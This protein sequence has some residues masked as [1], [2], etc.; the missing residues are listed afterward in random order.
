[1]TPRLAL[2][3]SPTIERGGETLALPFERRGQLL[4]F[5]ALRR[6]WVG[7]AELAAMFWPEQPGKLAY[8]N[9][10][11]L[12]FRL[13]S[14]PWDGLIESQGGAV[15]CEAG[16]DVHDFEAALRTGLVAEA[17]ALRRGDLLAGFDDDASEAWSGWLSFERE[18][19]RSAWRGAVL[20]RLDAIDPAEGVELSAQLLE[21]D[22]LDEG[23]LSVHVS[24]LA[25]SGQQAR[26]RQAYREFSE[27]LEKDLG[28]A[29]GPALKALHEGLG[30]TAAAV[31]IE[32]PA[33]DDSFV[34]RSVELGRIGELLEQDDCRLVCL[35]G[36]GGVGKTRLARRALRQHAAGFPAGA[37]FVPLEDLSSPG[38]LGGQLARELGIAHGS[39]VEPLDSVIEFLRAR[40]ALLVLDNFEHLAAAAPR[41]A[42]LLDACPGVKI[43]VTSRV[44]TGLP[45]EWLLPL[46]GLPCPE[47]EDQDRIEAFDAARLFVKAARRFAPSLNPSVEAPSIVDICRQVEGLPLALEMAAAWTRFLTCEA[48]A[49]ELRGGMELLRTVD[50]TRPARHASIEAVFE[51]SWRLLTP[52]ERGGLARLSVFRGGFTPEAARAAGTP[53]PI[54]GALADKSLVRKDEARIF[55]HPLVQQMAAA[56]LG[57]E[58]ARENAHAAHARYFHQLLAQ[59]RGA[60]EGG[61]REA[62]QRLD[63]ELENCRVAWRWAATHA[64]TD[65]LEK[66][67]TTLLH[68][69]DH[70]GRH[71]EGLALMREALESPG[72]AAD[73]KCAA[74][75]ASFAAHLAYRLDRYAV[76]EKDATRALATAHS[77][78]QADAELQSLT[79]LGSL[80]FRLGRHADARRFFA[81]ALKLT[82]A[83]GALRKAAAMMANLALVEKAAGH[84]DESLRHLIES[85]AQYRGIGDAAGEALTL[86]NIGSLQVARGHLE[87]ARLHLTPALA[88]SERHGLSY[89]RALILA[90]LAELELKAGN[91]EA[92]Q[93][94]AVGGIELAEATGNRYLVSFLKLQ[95]ARF[96]LRRGDLRG[97]RSEIASAATLAIAIGQPTLLAECAACFGELLAAQG[98]KDCE[99]LVAAFASLPVN[100]LA[101]RIVVEADVAHAPLIALLRGSR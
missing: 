83:S 89:N 74:L 7:R 58:E 3:G 63:T 31:A 69:C 64:R 94:H 77:T 92:A 16:T 19:L 84:H 4:A 76:A 48:I 36:P 18:R 10:R 21:A 79:V 101:H 39:A 53:L 25:R 27:R 13:Q 57:E 90:N 60:V 49:A 11:K 65:A 85:L 24:C 98:E 66:S 61:D 75:L 87:S 88:L 1:M 93:R 22:P 6:A 70:L 45:G 52:I 23:A 30:P 54:L 26:A 68:F 82:Q 50:E 95:F 5:L 43:L 62:L 32:P 28:I 15:R 97:A 56:R 37:A 86:S 20:V 51:Q 72:V 96:A 29:P 42:K 35:V 38:E 14:P 73:P 59:L 78:G 67:A 17:L 33:L 80:G 91:H 46:E 99:R 40:R 55:L 2:F 8:A 41:L 100:E 44:R 12:L 81:K 71:E 34:G 9:L 47:P